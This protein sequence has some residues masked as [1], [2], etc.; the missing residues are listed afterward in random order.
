MCMGRWR[1][2]AVR[3]DQALEETLPRAIT[4][5]EALDD[6]P[7]EVVPGTM[8]P[9]LPL[10]RPLDGPVVLPPLAAAELGRAPTCGSV[11]FSQ[12]KILAGTG[13]FNSPC[14]GRRCGSAA[15]CLLKTCAY[16]HMQGCAGK[17][18]ACYY[19]A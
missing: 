8:G 2:V 13:M 9:P 19:V 10:F 12:G 17:F 6:L 1:E 3:P 15:A 18:L 16:P 11:S 14:C 7:I 5:R 4:A